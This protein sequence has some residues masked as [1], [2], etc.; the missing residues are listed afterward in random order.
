MKYKVKEVAALGGVTVRTLHHY[1]EIG[2][3]KP[4]SNSPAGY[5][6]YSDQNLQTLQQILFFREIGFDLLEIKHILDRPDFNR[7]RA[8]ESHRE[9]LTAKKQRLQD[10]I[11]TVDKTLN[12]LKGGAQM[13]KEDW[14]EGFDMSPIE[15]H[16][17]KYAAEARQ[18]Y[19][20]ATM[21]AVEKRTNKYTKEDWA[22]IMAKNDSINAKIVARMDQ[23]P[24]DRIS[25]IITTTVRWRSSAALEACM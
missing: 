16:K 7:K 18:K 5:R 11:N 20:D 15:E 1:D 9:L 6:L 3:L 12:E 17:K 13:E 23:G 14:F 10:M 2:L 19:G 24:T 8:L 25:L 21:D 22:E 4:E